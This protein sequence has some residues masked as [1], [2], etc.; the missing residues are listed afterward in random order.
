LFFLVSWIVSRVDVLNRPRT[1]A[2]EL[3]DRF[4]LGPCEMFHA[5]RPLPVSAGRHRPSLRIVELL[6]HADVERPGDNG[7]SLRLR[8]RMGRDAEAIGELDAEYKRTFL[9]RVTFENGNFGALWQRGRRVHP[10]DVGRGVDHDVVLV[11]R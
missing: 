1:D 6:P 4:P 10:L 3:Q 2:V 7:D 5:G 9:A 8:M 11:L